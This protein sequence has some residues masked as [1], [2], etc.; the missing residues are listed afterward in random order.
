MMDPNREEVQQTLSLIGEL[1]LPH[2]SGSLLSFFVTEA[3]HPVLAA[4]Y[5]NDRLSAGE[6]RSLVADWIYIVE[7]VTKDGRLRPPPD[8]KTQQEVRRRD[9]NRCCISGKAGTFWDPLL[10]MPVLPIPYGWDADKPRI[11]DMLGAFFT[12]PYR[13]WWLAQVED[14]ERLP[15]CVGHWLV[16]KSAAQAFARGI[17]VLN[18]RLPSMIEYEVVPIVIGPE[19]PFEVEGPYALLG[20]HSR[21]G[22]LPVD[23]HFIGTQ[24]RLARSIRYVELARSI[25]PQIFLSHRPASP[26]RSASELSKR[27]FLERAPSSPTRCLNSLVHFSVRAFFTCWRVLPRRTRATAYNM[28]RKLGDLIYGAEDPT[29]YVRRL[30]FGLYLKYRGEADMARNEFNALQRIHRETTIPAP[31]P[32]DIIPSGADSSYLLMTRVPGAPLWRCESLFSDRDCAEIVIQLQDYVAQLRGLPKKTTANPADMAAICNTLGEACRDHRIRDA[33]P[34]GPFPDEAA[35]SQCVRFSDEPSRRGHAVVFTHA[36]LNP[37]NILV[38]RF[39]RWDGSTGWRV[40]GVVDWE[41]AGYYL[42]YWDYTKALFEGFRWTLRYVR[43]VYRVFVEFGDY[44]RELDVERRS[45][46]SGNGV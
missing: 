36:D 11:F 8:A 13:D 6:A 25:A 44:S 40:T 10:V 29:F 33:A 21:S 42:E 27:P 30:P 18:R 38:G 22:I 45:W 31:T 24:A 41:T 7:S 1:D 39:R 15:H 14:P 20:D 4:D 32:L 16:R 28:L 12:P 23:P 9:G 34:V 46:E 17:V 43:M 3:L 26:T 35:F 37:R 19:E 2:P 5:V